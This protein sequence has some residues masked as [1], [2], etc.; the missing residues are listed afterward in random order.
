MTAI[1]RERFARTGMTSTAAARRAVR[2]ATGVRSL[3]ESVLSI[4]SAAALRSLNER[5]TCAVNAVEPSGK[6]A[7]H[8]NTNTCKVDEEGTNE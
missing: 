3:F 1:F 8:E 6:R 5:K 4:V 2:I 7:Q